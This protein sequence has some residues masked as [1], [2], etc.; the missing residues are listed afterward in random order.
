[1]AAVE[2]RDGCAFDPEA[3]AV[4]LAEQPDLGTKWA[5]RFVR[6]VPSLPVTGTEKIAKQPL[7]TDGWSCGDPIWW[8]PER[9]APYR[10]LTDD[11]VALLEAELAT[12]GRLDMLGPRPVA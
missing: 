10:R 12:H 5:P 11:D 4:F 6:V 3:F 8:R 1:M 9:D 2:L 7:R